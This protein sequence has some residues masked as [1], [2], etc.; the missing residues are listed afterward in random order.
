VIDEQSLPTEFKRHRNNPSRYEINIRLDPSQL[1][2]YACGLNAMVSM[3]SG[4]VEA[5]ER[6][7]VPAASSPAS[8]V[9]SIP[10]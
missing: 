5:T 3:V 2:V 6:L 4:L 10:D 7:D 8:F 1:D 9:A